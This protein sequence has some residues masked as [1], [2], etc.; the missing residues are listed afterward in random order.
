[1]GGIED[2]R[3][4]RLGEDGQRAHVG[5]ERVV[6]EGDAALGQEHVGI[7]GADELRHHILHVPG[8]E[9]LPLLDVD[10]L[11]R[12]RRRQKQIGLAA[13]K[14][15][16]LQAVHGGRDLGA[17]RRLMHVGDDGEPHALTDLGEDGER[18]FHAEPAR[19]LR[20]RAVRFVERGFVDEAEPEPLG[21]LG[22]RARRL[23]PMG[24]AFQQARTGDHG[25]RQAIAEARISDRNDR[26]RRGLQGFIHGRTMEPEG[27]SV[28]GPAPLFVAPRSSRQPW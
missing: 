5:D 7:A 9:E 26:A 23:E 12:A 18:L 14:G 2:H 13:E 24:A 6:A 27:A 22:Q 10:G 17:L 15:R 21:H 19:T 28:N 3:R 16:D 1:M 20:A 8:G 4:A 25:E 11:A